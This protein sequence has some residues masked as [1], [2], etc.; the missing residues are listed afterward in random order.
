MKRFKN[1]FLYY[2]LAVIVLIFGFVS[3]GYVNAQSDGQAVGDFELVQASKQKDFRADEQPVVEYKFTKKRRGLDKLGAWFKSWV[4]DEYENIEVAATISDLPEVK[5]N[6]RY[7]KNGKFEIIPEEGA[8]LKPGKHTL[9]IS[10]RD[11]AITGGEAISFEQ[12]FTWGVLAF[13]PD[14][15]V[16]EPGDTAYLQFAVLDDN[17]DTLCDASIKVDINGPGWGNNDT[18]S[19]ADG[20]IVRNPDC[21][22]NNVIDTPDYYSRYKLD[23]PGI[24]EITVVAETANGPRTLSDRIEVSEKPAFTVRREGPTR[25]WP[26]ADYPMGIFVT[27]AADWQGDIIETVPNGF[28]IP[29]SA[30]ADKPGFEVERDGDTQHLIWKNIGLKAGETK[31]LS[32]TFD[33]PDRSPEFYLL[34]PLE[35]ISA[36]GGSALGGENRKWQIASDKTAEFY[37][38][39]A[40]TEQTWS[41]GTWNNI[42]G[43]PESGTAASTNGWLDN[44][45]FTVGER[46]LIIAQGSH[47]TGN[48]NQQSGFRVMHGGTAFSESVGIEETDRTGAAYRGRYFWFTVWTAADEDIEIQSYRSGDTAATDGVD[49]IAINAEE[50]IAHGDLKWAVATA[51]AGPLTTTPTAKVSTVWRPLR[52]GDNWLTGAYTQAQTVGTAVSFAARL[53]IDSGTI[54]SNLQVE[55]ER[56][57]DS[58]VYGLGWVNTYSVATH[59]V[60]VEL[61]ETAADQAWNAAGVFA[62]RLDAFQSS[63]AFSNAASLTLPSDNSYVQIASSAYTPLS[64]GYTLVLGG[65]MA[66]DNDARVTS[67][68]LESGSPLTAETGGWQFNVTDIRPAMVASLN[69]YAVLTQKVYSVN[70]RSTR[71][72]V[73][74]AINPWL[75]AFSMEMKEPPTG[76]FGTLSQKSNGTGKVDIQMLIDDADNDDCKA[77]LEYVLGAACSFGTSPARTTLSEVEVDTDASTG[78]PLVLNAWAYQIGTASAPILTSSGANMVNVDWNTKTDLPSAN[79]ET[80]CL[81]LTAN[82]YYFDQATPATATVIIDNIAPSISAII[83]DNLMYKIG[84]TLRATV[85]VASEP[86][87][88]TIGPGST[89]NGGA[90]TNIQKANNTTFTV[91]HIITAGESD[92]WATGTIPYLIALVDPNGN[93][94]AT[95]SGNFANGSLDANAPEI[96]TIATDDLLYGIGDTLT[97]TITMAADSGT[98]TLGNS[99]INGVVISNLQKIAGG[100]G[101]DWYDGDWLFR[102]K[103]TID[104]DQVADDLSDFPVLISLTNTNLSNEARNDGYD[105]IFTNSSNTEELSY[106]REFYDSDS[107]ELVAWVK[108]DLSSAVDTVL[109]MYYGNSTD[110]TDH[111]TTT[112]VW[113]SSYV[114]VLHLSD[115]VIDEGS[116]A[117]A[118]FDSTIYH[119]DGDQY[120]NNVTAGYFYYGQE[121]DGADDLITIG[122]TLSLD[123]SNAVTLELWFN[124]TVDS[125]YGMEASSTVF[126]AEGSTSFTVPDGVTSITV[127][128]WGGGG[129]GG[130]GGTGDVGAAGAGAGFTQATISVTPGETLDMYIGGGGGGGEGSNAEAAGGGGGGGYSDV[131]RSGTE[132]VL[133]AGGGGGGGGDDT[134]GQ[135]GNAGGVGGGTSGTD[136]VDEGSTIGGNGGTPSSGG[137]GGANAGTNGGSLTGGNGGIGGSGT[138]CGTG[139]CSG[140]NGGTNGG[141]TGGNGTT[142]RGGG[143]GGGGGYYGGGGGGGSNNGAE[144][145]CGGGGGSS[146]AT[147]TATGASTASGSGTNP[148]NAGDSDRGTAGVG[149]AS[150]GTSSNGSAGN[151]GRIVIL[152]DVPYVVAGTSTLAG[153]DGAYD[154][155]LDSDNGIFGRINN[156]E[157]SA[158]ATAGWHHV[159]LTYDSSLGGTEEMKIYLDGTQE[160]AGDY[161][162]LI[163]N[164]SNDILVGDKFI[165]VIDELRVSDSARSAAWL[166]TQYNNQSDVNNFISLDSQETTADYYRVTYTISEGDTDRASGTIPLSIVLKDTYGNENAA[167]IS[168]LT[169][170]SVDAHRPVIQ[171]VYITNDNYKI[172][173]DISLIIDTAESGLSIDAASTVNGKSVHSL[174]DN[175]DTTYSVIYTVAEG[176]TDRGINEI[177]ISIVMQD[178]YGNVNTAYTNPSYNTAT[179]DAN[180]PEIVSIEI[181]D[182]F[183]KIGDTVT[184]TITVASDTDDY[185][186][187][188]SS[189]NWATSTTG[190]L[191]KVS[192]TVYTFDYTV[193]EG[194][195][196][197]AS[198]T[199]PVWLQLTD[200]KGQYNLTP[201]TA[202]LANDARLDANSPG[203]SAVVFSPA[204]GVL[205]VG[206]KATATISMAGA[207]DNCTVETATIN[208]VNV[209]GTF[210]ELGGGEYRFVYTV[211][212]GH[213]DHPD[214]DDLPVYF[215]FAD[216][217]GNASNPYATA[218]PAHRPGVDGHTPVISTVTLS[219]ASGVLK[220]GDKATATIAIVGGE[221]GLSAGPTLTINGVDT[222]ATFT[223]IGSGNYRV[224]Y[225]VSE[226]NTDIDDASDLP[227][228]LTVEDNAGNISAAYTTADIANRPGVDGHTPAISSVTFTPSSGTLIVGD[229]ATATIEASGLEAGLASGTTM[230]INGSDISDTFVASATAGYYL[231]TYTVTE[232]DTDVIDISEDLVVSLTIRDSAYNESTVFNTAD[233]GNRPGVDG[234]TPS[235]T[236][237]VFA[238]SSGLLKVGDI[239]TATISVSGAETGLLAGSSMMIN[240]IDVSS[241]FNDITGGNYTVTYTV[242]EGHNDI[243]DIADLPVY[244][245]IVDS[246]GNESAAYYAAD[247]ANRPGVDGHTPVIESVV[248]YPSEGTLKV[249]DTATATIKEA[250]LEAGLASGTTMIIN[251]VDVSDTF[252]ASATAGYY[253]VTY[254]VTEGDTDVID[255]SE[256]LVV[257]LTIRDSAYNESAVFNTADIGNRPGVDGHT[258]VI[259][260]VTFNITSGLLKVGDI[261]TATIVSDET[262]YLAGMITINSVDVSGTLAPDTGNNYTVTYAV[263]EGD[264]DIPDG[265]DL[266]I[267]ISLV[268][269]AGNVSL[270]YTTADVGNRPGVDANTP[271]IPGNLS[272]IEHDNNTITIQFGATSTESDFDQYK[273]FYKIGSSGVTE[274]DSEWNLSDDPHLDDQDFNFYST[275]TVTGLA[276]G[277]GYVF[278]IWAYDQ[279]GNYAS[280]T[281]ELAATTNFQPV[282]PSDLVQ[283]L[284]DNY[285]VV[286]NNAWAIDQSMVLS[287]TSSDQDNEFTD[288]YFEVVGATSTFTTATSAPTASCNSGTGYVECTEK[289]WKQSTGPDWFDQDWLY[290]KQIVIDSDL[291]EGDLQD[292]PFLISNTDEDLR[293]N[294]LSDG[295]DI[296]F[297]AADGV[298]EI[299][300]ERKLY[301]DTN[302]QLIA[303]VKTNLSSSA[304]TFLYMYY[305][306]SGIAYDHS[307]TT[308]VWD[309]DYIGV[310]HMDEPPTGSADD[311]KDSSSYGHDMTSYNMDSSKRIVTDTGYA[312]NFD[313]AGDYLEDD[314]GESYINGLSAFTV[315]I[316]LKSDVIA[317]DRGFIIG[318]QPIGDDSFF[319]L[320]Y[321]ND[322]YIGYGDDVLKGAI[323]TTVTGEIQ[324]E[325]SDFLQTTDWQHLV[326]RWQSGQQYQLLVNGQVDTPTYNDPAGT[327]LTTG[328]DRLRIGQGGKD[329]T[330]ALG[331]DGLIDEVRISSVYRG[332]AWEKTAYNNQSNLTDFA[333][334]GAQDAVRIFNLPESSD[335]YK[336]QVMACDD[337]GACSDWVRYNPT[338]PNFKVDNTAPTAPG[339]LWEDSHDSTSVTLN[340]GATSTESFF[341]EYRIYYKI[342]DG[343]PVSTG[344]SLF[345]S[346]DDS[347]LGD[348]LFNGKATTTIPYLT[349]GIQYEFNIWA[350]DESGQSASATPI[351]VTTDSSSNHPTGY[352][353][354]IATSTDGSGRI[355]VSI[356]VGDLDND[357]SRAMI[358]YEAGG[359]CTFASPQD[360]TVDPLSISADNLPAPAVDNDYPYQIGT[361]SAYILTAPFSNTIT[362]DW[363]AMLDEPTAN[364]T[365]CLRLTVNDGQFDQVTPAT[366]TVILDNVNPATPGNLTVI[367]TSTYSAKIGFGAESSDTH[368]DRYYIYYKAGTSGVTTHDAEHYDTDLLAGDFN[369]TGSTTISGLQPGTD[370]VVNIWAYDEYGNRATATEAAFRTNQIPEAPAALSQYKNDGVTAIANGG[371]TNENTFRLSAGVIDDDPGETITLY[372][373]IASTTDSFTDA[374]SGAC[375][376]DAA[377]TDCPSRVWQVISAPGYYGLT[378]FTGVAEP[379]GVP[380]EYTGLKWQVMACDHDNVCS[381]WSDAGADPNLK[382]DHTAPGL[383]G[384]LT[385]TGF[386]S[387]TATL[388]FGEAAGETNFREYIIYYKPGTN[389]VTEDDTPYSSTTD[390]NLADQ[391]FNSATSTQIGGL[392]EGQDYVF[393]IWAYDEAGNSA[394]PHWKRQRLPITGQPERS[395]RRPCGRTAAVSWI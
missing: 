108:T 76:V 4:T 238:P 18:L 60:A 253:L 153:K 6:A 186:L 289:I 71:G 239:A 163:S 133:A 23:K 236:G 130:G 319:T 375:A 188:T 17:G 90:V 38:S 204:S 262:G 170:G 330:A 220:V 358:E 378:P 284:N 333:L 325:G 246:H 392:D 149:G 11:Q 51:A 294:A 173:S 316:W 327:G 14:Q 158:S 171:A 335:G 189:I 395:I 268:D 269:D 211:S 19:T 2:L 250:N 209:I 362:F 110:S 216:Q 74:A 348:I 95:S 79:G 77:K 5:V 313:G 33:A 224:V 156:Q 113:D 177:P 15:S 277:T 245:K 386:T 190:N 338:T 176:D 283:K 41:S 87:S 199:I 167:Y 3:I 146:F 55:G 367:S 307:T 361:T 390:I 183:Y 324:Y 291:V 226:G 243:N 208:N 83:T 78:D 58:P 288:Y 29:H 124:G 281:V 309:T 70:A 13:N 366:A 318:D 368:F 94:S 103:I 297:T 129:G 154:L 251:G 152:Y 303:W 286:A 35:A 320:R 342:Y 256:D 352:F 9:S 111:A 351:T 252:M 382:V 247:A 121:F 369:Q 30:P 298:T 97:A 168:P 279:A 257:S 92:H 359:A 62:L 349:A 212:E 180:R 145:A 81:R 106:E 301:D 357:P 65:F 266:P 233:I 323:T 393:N 314:D 388:E 322:G 161:S 67:Y 365:Y 259:S 151:A 242:Q 131:R 54:R 24:Y 53:N 116:A 385:I 47:S 287:A 290:R 32:Y 312:Y 135:P 326:F 394:A 27:A 353:N 143:G 339:D 223:D 381:A 128:A 360:P 248:F 109:Y 45:N 179:I 101:A 205:K 282:D 329:T 184:A 241:T 231:V 185:S 142:Y 267:S 57:V 270:A 8:R 72:V 372:F 340:F 384:N 147:S 356:E 274:S 172:G 68:M 264:T 337:Y 42:A 69:N 232:G 258:P 263:Q 122:D 139:E 255:I 100:S 206:D 134:A 12:D 304:D 140:G 119:N 181:P 380:D 292:F 200:S 315:E 59:T 308:G 293:R 363:L 7:D 26:K 219:P 178:K 25:I 66:D 275:T 310:W 214:N 22:P 347:N 96:I 332:D 230:T 383:P 98:Y 210:T 265:N 391:N 201:V 350:F 148:G 39:T 345:D 48:Q 136:A 280:A 160:A 196:D 296:I 50:L 194:D 261:A 52:A 191:N 82:D 102:Q 217:V 276:T 228:N 20:A 221:T 1:K 389:G 371:W 193:T 364:G 195:S 114:D 174:T 175:H 10:V 137:A 73:A 227:V 138:A 162:S 28:I 260:D 155:I 44:S 272:Y 169:E 80:Y 197:R 21:G 218:D 31:K 115:S 300:Y 240:L 34:G 207:E 237:V 157:I 144:G 336:W 105:I 355:N 373:E 49:L 354:S 215:V 63:A 302:G 273:I 125:G 150:G 85:T 328:A 159:A 91:D 164:N 88:L 16:Y 234:N 36:Q 203:I 64:S 104:S 387:D 377:W 84:D 344:N 229:T 311:I 75:V 40:T 285:T 93:K 56:A 117:G 118:H 127:K 182:W 235:I 225:T 346:A 249:G 202:F 43:T 192:D 86:G 187:G 317:S 341:D 61:Y 126:S 376:H 46:Y 165:G 299:N 295:S 306:N 271:S 120:G 198:G 370:Y 331:W 254:T 244:F 379:T 99:T 166:S 112:G 278:N 305:G 132:L 343:T 123:A 321:D 334:M 222:S 107:G 374:T 89:I 37:A 141:G 213:T